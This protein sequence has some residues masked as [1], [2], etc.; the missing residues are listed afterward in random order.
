MNSGFRTA[1]STKYGF[2]KFGLSNSIEA[3]NFRTHISV[4]AKRIT[5]FRRSSMASPDLIF[6][7]PIDEHNMDK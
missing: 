3:I 6:D 4:S 1:R 5:H 2:A 7:F